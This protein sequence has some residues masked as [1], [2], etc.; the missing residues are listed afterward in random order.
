MPEA[1]GHEINDDIDT[2]WNSWFSNGRFSTFLKVNTRNTNINYEID[3]ER[4]LLSG[5]SSGAIPVMHTWLTQPDLGIKAIYL[6]YPLLHHYSRTCGEGKINIG[7]V[8]I[9]VDDMNKYMAS[10]KDE[11]E[12]LISGD[13]CPIRSASR[14]PEGAL[15][16]NYLPICNRWKY[17]YNCDSVAER[18]MKGTRNEVPGTSPQICIFH[19]DIDERIPRE[20]NYDVLRAL[21][22]KW[23]GKMM[24][25]IHTAK[26]VG[27]GHGK[28]KDM[29]IRD[30][31]FLQ[32]LAW[33]IEREWGA[34]DRVEEAKEWL[35]GYEM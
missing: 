28:D 14:S 20:Q 18:I 21:T 16:N 6:Q 34:P 11:L 23:E 33:I 25:R 30:A 35:A 7:G 9:T 29:Q 22:E 19:G 3:Y 13:I 1:D 26:A 27:M 12:R 5:D 10:Y 17:A 24:D 15:M 31:E 8:E 4:I 32:Y 2:F